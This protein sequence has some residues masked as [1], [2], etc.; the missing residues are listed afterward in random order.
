[1][2]NEHISSTRRID[3][4]VVVKN[5]F[6]LY[7]KYIGAVLFSGTFLLIGTYLV[8]TIFPNASFLSLFITVLWSALIQTWFIRYVHIREQAENKNFG[9]ILR[10]TLRYVPDALAIT[11][12]TFTISIC[13]LLLLVIPGIIWGVMFSQALFYVVIEGKSIKKSLLQSRAI[14]KGN[15]LAVFRSYFG[16]YLPFIVGL[17]LLY[18]FFVRT[19]AEM[20]IIFNGLYTVIIGM[21]FPIIGYTLYTSLKQLHRIDK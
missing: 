13:G 18:L 9:D 15:R 20:H 21:L 17:S 14:T 19:S 7:K 6:L 12:I 1:M 5:S 4:T 11:A 10:G 2:S 3:V 8:Q 16:V